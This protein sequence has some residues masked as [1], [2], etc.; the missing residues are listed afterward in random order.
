LSVERLDDLS[1][2]E[3][4]EVFEQFLLHPKEFTAFLKTT[5]ITLILL[6][7]HFRYKP[8]HLGF[9]AA[10]FTIGPLQGQRK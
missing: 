3:S 8:V 1:E 2:L 4:R 5:G 6:S 10:S 7:L 9:H